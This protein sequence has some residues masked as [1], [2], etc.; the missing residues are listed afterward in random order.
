MRGK[1]SAGTALAGLRQSAWIA[2]ALC[3]S[4]VQAPVFAWRSTG[5][6]TPSPGTAAPGRGR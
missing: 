2:M 5:M 3:L 4:R 1:H 6:A